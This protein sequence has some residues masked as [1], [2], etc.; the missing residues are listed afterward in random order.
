[1]IAP[2]R[3]RPGDRLALVAPA[4]P[5]KREELDLGVAEL[6]ALGFEAVYDE[7][8][9]LRDRYLA[10]SVKARA[11]VLMDAWRDPQVR[12]LIAI[13]GGYGSA[14]LLPFLD[15]DLVRRARKPFIGY[16]DL[17]ALLSW[18]LQLGLVSFHGPM[19]DRRFARGTE[20]YH[21]ES[22]LAAVSRPT[23]MGELTPET[24]EPFFPGEAHGVLVGGTLTQLAAS[25]GTPWAFDP[26]PG[27]VLFLE[28][29][30]ERPYRIDRLLTQ[31]Q[32][33]G[34]LVRASAIVFGVFPGCDEPGGELV[35]RDVLQTLTAGFPGPVVFGFPSGHTP[36][37]T[38][39]LPLG[40]TATVVCGAR[41]F[42]A[43]DE[44]AVE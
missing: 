6:A 3:L 32:Q 43:I 1:M 27:C 16:S 41:T 5:F 25:L 28:D 4:S 23:P 42:L 35:I 37:A 26:P 9:L 7:R 39:T 14:Q 21:R 15:A 19:I 11:A 36:G 18:H 30:S 22:F 40:V 13:R 10:G 2:H 31:L 34:I 44:P 33:A 17:T 12:G 24:L 20:A 8:V 38:W 29:V